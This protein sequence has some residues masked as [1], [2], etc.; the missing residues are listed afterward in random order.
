MGIIKQAIIG[1][2]GV[3]VQST[4]INFL[5]SLVSEF[6][7]A[8]ST[9]MGLPREFHEQCRMS[10]ELDYLQTFY[11][12]S[13]EAAVGVTDRIVKSD[14]EVPEAKVC[15]VAMRLML[16]I[17]N[18]DFRYS[19]GDSV[20]A[21]V[22]SFSAKATH[23]AADSRRS[24]C[25]LV[26]PGSSWQKI[27]LLS[28][29][30]GWVLN[31][32]G[33]LRHKFSLKVYWLD[34]PI[35]VSARKL[36][37]QLCS[38]SGNIFP[39]DNVQMR[40]HHLVQLLSGIIQW[41]HP[42]D[43][44]SRAI[45]CGKSESELLD[46]CRALLA[47]ATVT[48]P[49]MF[50]QLLKS[51]C[52]FGTI[53]LLS[54][55]M[56]EVV[57]ALMLT[58]TDE[59]TWSWVARDILLDTWTAVLVTKKTPM[60]VAMSIEFSMAVDGGGCGLCSKYEK[61]RV[62]GKLLELSGVRWNDCAVLPSESSFG[63]SSLP[64][65]GINAAAS[66][67]VLI[68]ESE[69]KTASATAYNDN[70][71]NDYLQAS[72][73]GMDERLNSYGL[74]ARAS[75]EYSVP[76][77]T[78]V[79]LERIAQLHQARGKSDPTAILEELYSLLLISGHVLADE[80]EGE[81]PMVPEA[82]QMHFLD[83]R[84]GDKHPVAV[85]SSS[86]L[87]FAEQSIDPEIRASTFSPRL[88]E[89]VIWFLA[90]WS[91]T[92]LLSSEGSGKNDSSYAPQQPQHSKTVLLDYFGEHN[93]GKFVLDLIVRV[94][95]T[96]LVSYP[97]EKDLQELTCC[98]LF[99]GLVGRRE[100]S[101]HLMPLDSWRDLAKS[102][103][104]ERALFLLT[105]PH[106]RSLARTLVLSASGLRNSVTSNQCV[107][108]LMN[109]IATYLLDLCGKN[110]LKKLSPQPE[111]IMVVSC[112]L[113]RLRGAAS[114]S[115][116]WT[117]MAIYEIG[118]SVMNPILT[119]LEVY[120]NEPA[121]VYLLLKFVVQ[122]VGGQ[123]SYL[124]AQETATL[125]NFSMRLLQIYSS[126]N[127]GKVRGWL[128]WIANWELKYGPMKQ[129]WL[130]SWISISHSST[131]A[132]EENAEKYKD[133]RAL[134]Q[135]LSNLCSKDLI[136]F[137][138]G[139]VESESMSIAQVVYLGLHII[140]P[141]ISIDL[142]KY[143][144]LCHDYFSLVS[145]MLEVYPEM[146]GQLNAE[147]LVHMIGTLDFGLRYQVSFPVSLRV[148]A[149]LVVSISRELEVTAKFSVPLSYTF[150]SFSALLMQDSEVIDKCLSALKAIAAYHYKE[151]IAGNVGLGSH[152]TGVKDSGGNVQDGILS[153]FLPSL[154]QLLMFEDYS[155]DLVSAAADALLPLILCEQGL[156]QRLCNELIEKQTDPAFKTRLA[157]AFHALTS[158]NQLSSTLD[159]IN[160][161]RFRK[162]LLNFL[163]E[164]RGFLRMV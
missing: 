84:E 93:Q 78:K 36:I 124:E 58:D 69:L 87:H 139:T 98:H 39:A 30:V 67:F 75:I 97:G 10:L 91:R 149:G 109:H 154:L 79:F 54:S 80:G 70:D 37:V 5:E 105:A 96:T 46:G 102:F 133:L 126:H 130:R 88:M 73:F 27:L 116:S 113:E 45:E 127:I 47:V 92:Y 100:V 49:F 129:G 19:F 90:R 106:Q 40:E 11:S 118:V 31:L 28:G 20:K 16:Q 128:G 13:Q 131:L 162:N 143:P 108:D 52:P 43:V 22:D 15:T 50:D 86:I 83:T 160:Y 56:S 145:H 2:H 107:R 153:R 150:V 57:K 144:K 156:Y 152:A 164:V 55:L 119:L 3:D 115:D 61:V 147:A 123:I 24:E 103:A 77:L 146:V 32:Y 34:C 74:I 8:T 114:A 44:V 66:L 65:D 25:N 117:Q 48:S 151:T 21:N 121:V 72:I 9:A 99:R 110:D 35:A 60:M 134:I 51:I 104:N 148:L 142:L 132:N 140:S 53:T 125:I 89:A 95:M 23:D 41:V 18:W 59:E 163:I 137:S 120:K 68:V 135:L 42:P 101:A 1:C 62:M 71:S 14:S 136:D 4:G 29:H 159:R 157:S 7:P 122:W 111:T 63:D 81:L 158:S 82:V 17:L 33:A 161:Q 155:T 112:L 85:L 76:F 138:A 12:W 6:S 64:V 38:L 141:L 26:Q 94:S